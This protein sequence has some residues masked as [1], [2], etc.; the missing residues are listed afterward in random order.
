MFTFDAT[1]VRFP[2]TRQVGSARPAGGGIAVHV[3]RVW[4][5]AAARHD[6]YVRREIAERHERQEQRYAVGG[7][8]SVLP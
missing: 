1:R 3:R 4:A 8:F 5:I 7:D 6:A 2:L